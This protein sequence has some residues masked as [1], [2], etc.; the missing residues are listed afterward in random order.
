MDESCCEQAKSATT[1]R[2][3]LQLLQYMLQ[4]RKDVKLGDFLEQLRR[5]TNPQAQGRLRFAKSVARGQTAV[6]MPQLADRQSKIRNR[7]KQ[8]SGFKT[9]AHRRTAASSALALSLYSH[10]HG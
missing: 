1:T 4:P 9:C 10:R 2:V 8:I 7:R 6:I 5:I 3:L